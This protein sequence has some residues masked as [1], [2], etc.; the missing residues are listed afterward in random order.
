MQR[1]HGRSAR[2]RYQVH[3]AVIELLGDRTVDEL[4]IPLVAERSGVHQA[5]IYRRW[6]SIPVLLNDIL[7][8][9]PA[10]TSPL[11]DTGTLR[12]DLEEYATAVADSLAGPL[13][14]PMLR[15][16]VSNIRPEPDRGPSAILLERT[17]QLQD[18]LDRA[19][20]RGESPPSVAEL[21]ELVVAPL[22]FHALFGQPA[23]AEHARRLV[24]RLL[25]SP[26]TSQLGKAAPSAQRRPARPGPAAA[27]PGSD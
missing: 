23:D 20:A 13:G 1:P 9:G 22:Y 17:Q 8:A 16:A 3:R 11:P 27:A 14:V 12:G 19:E 21:L 4:S 7:A 10:R 24:D 5:T 2:I 26:A 15:A 25:A 18:M 6:G